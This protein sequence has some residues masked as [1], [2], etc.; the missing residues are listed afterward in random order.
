MDYTIEFSK[1][2]HGLNKFSFSI[3]E[4]FLCNFD[5]SPIKKADCKAK[6][7]LLKS[8][9]MLDLNFSFEGTAHCVCDI[10][11]DEFEIPIE[12]EFSLLIKFTDGLNNLDDQEII[13]LNR[14]EHMYDLS[15]FLYESF[16]LSIPTKKSCELANKK[17]NETVIE[18]LEKTNSNT[19][20]Q[21]NDP[22]W[23]K[24]KE[25]YKNN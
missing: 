21:T 9:N 13:Y 16:L 14:K 11:L 1:L 12:N 5:F 24:L 15:A 6:L 22:R 4:K 17:H 2:V 7:E 19:E 20:N 3:D 18:K 25:L 23:D 8:E 10:C